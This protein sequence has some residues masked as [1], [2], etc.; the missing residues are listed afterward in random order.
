MPKSFRIQYTSDLHLELYKTLPPFTTF[1]KPCAPYLALVGDIGHPTQL[2]ELFNWAT[3]QPEWKRIFYVAG[4]HEFYGGYYEDRMLEIAEIAATFENVHFLHGA[5]PS[6]FCEEENVA[7]IGST[8][9]S[10]VR[11]RDELKSI[12]DYKQIRFHGQETFQA[13][14]ELHNREKKILDAQIASWTDKGAVICVLTHY[15][16]SFRLIHPRYVYSD[17]NDCFASMSDALLRPAVRLWIYGHSH[18]C[19]HQ[20]IRDILCVCNARG[21]A[22]EVV[23]GWKPDVWMGFG[24]VDP[25]EAEAAAK[26]NQ[27]PLRVTETEG[28]DVEFM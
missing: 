17:L 14:N 19:S 4:N 20:S 26:R 13:L 6:F 8:L 18:C 9:W 24:C 1:L 23:A 22:D 3:R 12:S 11:R 5:S 25:Q 21:Y 10:A 27:T 2:K 15:L 16:P 7:V 28:D